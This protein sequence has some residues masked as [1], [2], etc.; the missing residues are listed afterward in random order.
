MQALLEA[1]A[2]LEA[3]RSDGSTTLITASYMGHTEVVQALLG[4]GAS[5]DP[6]DADG[7][8]LD[9]AIKQR[10]ASPNPNPN[11]SASP[12]PT[13]LTLTLALTLILVVYLCADTLIAFLMRSHLQRSLG[14]L[15]IHHTIVVVGVLCYMFPSPPRALFMYM[16][17]EALTAL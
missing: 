4:A 10:R 12:S 11:S 14:P 17:G 7:T 9:N 8:A 1:R 15:Y 6:R 3:T 5:L 13:T 2:G 16:W